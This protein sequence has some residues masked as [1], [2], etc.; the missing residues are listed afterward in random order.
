MIDFV[1][2]GEVCLVTDGTHYT[3]PNSGG[4]FPFL[5][6]KDMSDEGLSFHSCSHISSTEFD[7]AKNAGACPAKGDVLFSKDGTVGKVH[8]VE[9]D[10]DF[11]VLSSIAILR[12]DRERLSSRYLGYALQAPE[13][14]ADAFNRKTG[15]ALQRIILSDLKKVQIPLPSLSIQKAITESLDC[16]SKLRRA[17]RYALQL[18]DEISPA[19]FLNMFG[20]PIKNPHNFDLVQLNDC[21]TGIESGYSPVCNGP[22]KNAKDWAVLGLGAVTWGLFDPSANKSL[23]E[24]E[25]PRGDLEVKHGDLLVTRKNTHDLV[26]ASVL[27]LNPPPRLLLPDTIFRFQLRIDSRLTKPYLWALFSYPSFKAKVQALAAG[28]A[29][30]MPGISK[31]KFLTVRCPA[32]P[33]EMQHRFGDLIGAAGL[34][35]RGCVEALRQADHL[36]QSLLHRAFN[37][38]L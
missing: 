8:V 38:E 30:S 11:A 37:G 12:P 20:D 16:A 3:P 21:L 10:R 2:L 24:S 7:K 27:V 18:C 9:K 33:L 31:E 35:R 15:S 23:P 34:Q 6:V 13:I 14:L 26:A 19:A 28:S 32:P 25:I 17:R 1:T 4:P 5:T 29:G 22:R 36:F